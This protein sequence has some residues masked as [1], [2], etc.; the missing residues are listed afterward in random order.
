MRSLCVFSL[1]LG[2]TGAVALIPAH[3]GGQAPKP[4]PAKPAPAKPASP[5]KTAPAGAVR[6]IDIVGTDDMKYDLTTIT[7]KRGEQLRVRLIS[8]GTLPKIAMAHNFVLLKLGANQIKFSEAAAQARATDF[9]PP[10]MKAQVIANTALA[11]PGE[12]VEVTFKVPAA[13]GKY[14]YMCTFPG[15]FAAGMRGTLVVK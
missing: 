1:V 10:D 2:L 12:T 5:A 9:I 13:A 3:A 11:G 6:T 15:H 7:A 8:K 4:A 14:P